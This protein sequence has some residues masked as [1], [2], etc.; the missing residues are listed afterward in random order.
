MLKGQQAFDRQ[1]YLLELHLKPQSIILFGSNV[2][3]SIIERVYKS[4][5]Y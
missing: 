2:Q 4:I 1:F 5:K 3:K